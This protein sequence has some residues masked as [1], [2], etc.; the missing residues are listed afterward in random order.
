[1][2]IPKYPITLL[3]SLPFYPK[4][5]KNRYYFGHLSIAIENEIYQVYNP[6]LLKASFLVSKMSLYSWLYESADMWY[7][8]D[9][10]SATY[11]SVHL[12]KKP[13]TTR[14]SV[15]YAGIKEVDNTT[16][17]SIKKYFTDLEQNHAD[18]NIKFD[19]SKKNCSTFIT[20]ILVDTDLIKKTFFNLF[21]TLAYKNFIT[22]NL[23]NISTGVINGERD[24]KFIE[25]RFAFPITSTN[26]KNHIINNLKSLEIFLGEINR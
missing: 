22:K 9:K 2:K 18:K 16:I 24:N 21:P 10:T 20:D 12:Y 4:Q 17:D 7:D 6:S 26:P 23:S 25:H 13:E 11:R 15:F 19:L 5:F 14:T 1:M 8:N 3:L